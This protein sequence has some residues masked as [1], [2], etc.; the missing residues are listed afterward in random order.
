V[1]RAINRR[2]AAISETDIDQGEALSVLRYQ[3][4]QQFR[5]HHDAIAGVANQRTKTVLLYLNDG[6]VGGET[7]FP[8]TDMKIAP[9]AGDA[10]VFTNVDDAG[11]PD[12]LATH[13]GLPVERGVKW[14]ATRWIRARPIDPWNP[15]D[16]HD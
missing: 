3:P 12:P 8:A 6:F 13:A 5:L 10:I 9:V 4:A 1:I 15:A 16:Q 14:L 7:Y 11:R 2:I